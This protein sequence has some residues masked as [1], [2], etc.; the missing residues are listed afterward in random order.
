MP[1]HPIL[2]GLYVV[3]PDDVLLPRLSAMVGSALQGG[4]RLVQYRNK[5]APTPL[6]RSQAAELLRICRASDAVLIIND[7]VQLTLEIGADGVHLGGEDGDLSA[8]RKALGP[9][10]LLGASCYNDLHRAEVAVRAGAD[11]L[12]F[13]SMFSSKTKA[14]TVAAPLTIL[15][16]A[17]RFGLPVA[18][19]G[20]ITV[21]NAPDVIDSGAD[22][23]AV[24]SD[25]F[26]TLD[27]AAR[28]AQYQKLF[29][30][31]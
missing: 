8:A 16:E 3:T 19:I 11:Y 4:A 10:R 7:D 14:T 30:P 31:S 27:M 25:L 18:A 5:S 22:M 9:H 29:Q 24:I 21:D 23:V 28:V 2:H 17:K 26:D 6:R 20:G 15:T 13:G 12:A 1:R